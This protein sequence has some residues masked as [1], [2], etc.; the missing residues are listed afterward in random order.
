MTTSAAADLRRSDLLELKEANERLAFEEERKGSAFNHAMPVHLTLETTMACSLRCVMCQVYRSPAAMKQGLV[1]DPVMSV[2]LF[3]RLAVEAFPTAKAMTPTVMGE[4]LQTPFLPRMLELLS[5]YSVKMNMVTSGTLLTRE[6]SDRLLPHLGKIKVSFDGATKETFESIRRG[7]KFEKVV[8]NIRA[9]DAERRKLGLSEPP[10]LCLQVTLMRKNIEELP[11]IVEI[12]SELGVDEVVGLHVYVFDQE[13]EPQSLL[14]HRELSDRIV[15]VATKRARDLGIRPHFPA[16][17]SAKPQDVSKVIP[18]V[19]GS[20][21]CKFLWREVWVSHTGDVTPCCVPDRPVAGNVR[22]SRFLDVWNG[23]MYQEMRRTVGS[24]E[25]F[26]CCR[27]CSLRV[28]YEPGNREGY[29]R[30]RFLLS[31]GPAHIRMSTGSKPTSGC[32]TSFFR[33]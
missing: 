12:A 25:P 24:E 13:F 11:R 18:T 22:T 17:Y 8:D 16:P 14:H 27:H 19:Q 5:T 3:E 26:D 29:D 28:Q 23:E 32:P 15:A 7:S 1:G 31:Q 2:E 4:P 9:F 10:V 21:L 33:Y 6:M 30:E 20:A